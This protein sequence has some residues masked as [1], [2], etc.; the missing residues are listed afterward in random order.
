MTDPLTATTTTLTLAG[1]RLAIDAAATRASERGEPVC[2]SVCD[3]AGNQIAFVRMDGAPLLSASIAADKAYTVAA[4]GPDTRD[5]WNL[6]KD[7]P[8]L[9]AGIVKTD[10]LVVFGG[11][12]AVHVDGT[13]VGAIG[14][15]GSTSEGDHEI[16]SAGAA[17]VG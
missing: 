12:V 11:G 13:K 7:E 1:A 6:I 3:I 2:I 14:V 15:S 16:A 8:A 17:A 4:F 10:R 5:W 9:L